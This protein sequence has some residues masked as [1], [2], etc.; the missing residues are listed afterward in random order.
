MAV[1]QDGDFEL[2]GYLFSGSRRRPLYVLGFGIEPQRTRVQDVLNP[3]APEVL[4]GRDQ[5]TPPLWKFGFRVGHGGAA[6][7]LAALAELTAAWN[8]LPAVPGA[9]SVLRYAVAGRTR[10]VYGR[11]RE[12]FPDYSMVYDMGRV[13][14]SGDF[15][16]RDVW[17]YDD[18]PRSVTV[19]LVPASTGGLI[20]PLRSPLSTAAGSQRQGQVTVGG[21]APAPVELVFKG[22]VTNPAAASTGWEVGLNATIAYDQTVTVNTRTGTVLRNDGASLS[23][24]LTRRTYL[25]AARLQPGAR[26]LTFSGTDPTGTATCTMRWRD[27]YQ[28]L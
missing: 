4:Q 5:R 25:P 21:D 27:T 18:V 9:E 11:A 20:A 13:V 7:T 14:S 23:G 16:P 2:D 6:A 3:M 1:L 12:M 15:Q 10:L 22:P 19:S 26:E 8:K 24:V 28:S 17:F